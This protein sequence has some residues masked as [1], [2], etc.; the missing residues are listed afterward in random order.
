M[1]TSNNSRPDPGDS[2]SAESAPTAISN[3]EASSTG[4]MLS[5]KKLYLYVCVCL[6]V[7]VQDKVYCTVPHKLALTLAG[8]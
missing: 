6:C 1:I 2:D 8:S 3:D 5:L 7:C 4:S